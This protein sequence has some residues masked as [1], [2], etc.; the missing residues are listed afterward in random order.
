MASDYPFGIFIIFLH[1]QQ[2]ILNYIHGLHSCKVGDDFYIRHLLQIH[3]QS[4]MISYTAC[5]TCIAVGDLI[6]DTCYMYICCTYNGWIFYFPVANFP[7]VCCNVSVV[8]AYGVYIS[9]FIRYSRACSSYHNYLIEDWWNGEASET[10][11]PSG[12]VD[13][14]TSKVEPLWNIC[15]TE[16]P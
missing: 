2:V 15:V 6:W 1:F 13:V 11:V 16:I 4:D 9:Q 10:R 7:F 5:V 3:V 14:I 12:Y 8:P